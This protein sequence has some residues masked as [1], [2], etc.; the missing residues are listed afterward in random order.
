MKNHSSARLPFLTVFTLLLLLSPLFSV[1]AQES[2]EGGDLPLVKLIS[3][4]GTIGGPFEALLEAVPDLSNY[5]IVEGEQFASTGSSNITLSMLLDLAARIDEI[6]ETEPD[7]EAIIVSQGTDTLEETAYFLNLVVKSD[8]P[9]VMA[10]AMRG[11]THISADGPQNLFMAVL[12]AIAPE[13]QGKGVVAVINDEIHAARELTKTSTYSMDTFVSPDAGPLGL[14]RDTRGPFY[15]RTPMRLHTTATEFDVLG[16]EDLPRVDIIYAYVDA[17]DTQIRAAV[18]AGAQGI[19]VATVG[20]GNMPT[21]GMSDPLGD[22][23][24][25]HDVV[26]VRSS[27]TGSGRI[28]ASSEDNLSRGWV[29]GDNLNPQKAR[30][31]LM[32]ALTVTDDPA[33]IQ[34]IFNRY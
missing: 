34:E 1:Q 18:E 8:K 4:G 33:E 12:T 3:T 11:R 6:F 17:D 26:V 15:Y 22:V 16:F 31:L 7:V 14:V 13:T 24:L 19:V 25:D 5:A 29:G 20:A 32:L 9:V 21:P 2:E 10:A 23:W 27:R 28:N 30:M